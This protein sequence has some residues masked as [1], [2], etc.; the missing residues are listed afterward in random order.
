MQEAGKGRR[1]L[2]KKTWDNQENPGII[3]MHIHN[4]IQYIVYTAAMVRGREIAYCHWH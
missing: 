2:R 1:P 4:S 3:K